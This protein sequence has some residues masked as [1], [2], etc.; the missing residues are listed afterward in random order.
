MMERLI[1][2]QLP[3]RGR[4]L[5][6]EDNPSEAALL[7]EA[8]AGQQLSVDIQCVSDGEELLTQL[9]QISRGHDASRFDL[10]LLDL[11]LPRR[12]TEEVLTTLRFENLRLDVPVTV[13]SSNVSIEQSAHL[14]KLGVQ[15]ML[16]KPLDLEGYFELARNLSQSWCREA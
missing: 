13:L 5:L 9:R 3:A 11:H 6:A 12:S 10:I 2:T 7:E 16:L 15:T 14:R 1:H 8:F 4:I